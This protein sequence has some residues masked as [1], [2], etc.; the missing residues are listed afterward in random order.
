MEEEAREV[1]VGM[2]HRRGGRRSVE[3]DLGPTARDGKIRIDG[4]DVSRFTRAIRLTSSVD[5]VTT[6]E[7]EMPA[8]EVL[9]RL[10]DPF[11]IPLLDLDR[12]DVELRARVALVAEAVGELVRR[13]REFKGVPIEGWDSRIIA[14]DVV[15]SDLERDV[16]R[17]LRAAV[18]GSK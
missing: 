13:F 16:L 10:R 12:P 1:P 7:I 8:V 17:P 9:A 14:C 6:L 15:A 11:V 5:D 4:E 18:G 3:L 2:E